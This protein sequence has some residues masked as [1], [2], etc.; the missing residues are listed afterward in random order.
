VIRTGDIVMN[1][2]LGATP[3]EVFLN[4]VSARA[5]EAACLLM[6]DSLDLETL[7]SV[8]S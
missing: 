4:Q 5:I 8:L 7:M 6:V 2:D 1:V 3:A